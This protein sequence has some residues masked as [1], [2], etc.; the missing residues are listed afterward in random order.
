MARFVIQ[1]GRF[2]LA[3]GVNT[4]RTTEGA[5]VLAGSGILRQVTVNLGNLNPGVYAE[6]A[7]IHHGIAVILKSGTI[8]G[9]SPFG[10]GGGLFWQGEIPTDRESVLTIGGRNDSGASVGYIFGWVLET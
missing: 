9:P 8:R 7:V 1:N 10:E 3:T 6:I 5:N 4:D 2:T